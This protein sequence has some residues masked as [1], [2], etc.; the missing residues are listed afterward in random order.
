MKLDDVIPL[1]DMDVELEGMVSGT[2]HVI[3]EKIIYT[4]MVAYLCG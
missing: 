2:K 4:T 3:L 1:T